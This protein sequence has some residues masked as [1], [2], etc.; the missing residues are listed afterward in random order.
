MSDDEPLQ[1]AETGGPE[2]LGEI[3][4]R[5]D[6][7]L[8]TG[9]YKDVYLAYHIE[10][11][12]DVAWNT[13]RL[14]RIPL[15]ERDRIEQETSVLGKIS[16]KN[17]IKFFHVWTNDVKKEVCFTTEIVQGGSLKSFIARVFPV[18][19]RVMKKWCFQILDALQYLH[20]K[21]PPIIH[22]D[23]KC[24][25]IFINSKDSTLMIGDFG[26][27]ALRRETSVT[28]VLGTPQFMAPELYDESYTE[29]V[30][31][32]AFGMCVLEMATNDYPYAEC[33]NP[34]QIFK[35]VYQKIKPSIIKRIKTRRVREFIEICL[36]PVHKRLS[37]RQLKNHPFFGAHPCDQCEVEVFEEEDSKP[38][39]RQEP[40]PT[41]IP[42]TEPY[43]PRK[44]SKTGHHVTFQDQVQTKNAE[45]EGAPRRRKVVSAKA[46][47]TKIEDGEA[48]ITFNIKFIENEEKK[49]QVIEFKY[50]LET[51]S[52]RA[53]CEEMASALKL[54]PSATDIL[55]KEVENALVAPP[56][57]IPQPR[58]IKKPLPVYTPKA[59]SSQHQEPMKSS[60]IAEAIVEKIVDQA[61]T[62]LDPFTPEKS[63]K[64]PFQNTDVDDE[65]PFQ[66]I[67]DQ[68]AAEIDPFHPPPLTQN[69]S[70][71]PFQP[72]PKGLTVN[73]TSSPASIQASGDGE[74]AQSNGPSSKS[75]S[76]VAG[77][78]NAERI[79]IKL[80]PTDSNVRLQGTK[81]F[82]AINRMPPPRIHNKGGL[83][84]TLTVDIKE[85]EKSQ[86][87]SP[88]SNSAPQSGSW[89][90][91][92]TTVE[93]EPPAE[94]QHSDGVGVLSTPKHS[95]VKRRIAITPLDGNDTED[96][97]IEGK[98]EAELEAIHIQEMATLER[99][100]EAMKMRLISKHEKR[101]GNLKKKNSDNNTRSRSGSA[102]LLLPGPIT[103]LDSEGIDTKSKSQ[104]RASGV[105]TPRLESGD[106]S[107]DKSST[108]PL[109]NGLRAAEDV[110]FK[111]AVSRDISLDTAH[112]SS[113]VPTPAEPK[114]KNNPPPHSE[115]KE[116]IDPTIGAILTDSNGD[117]VINGVVG[118]FRPKV[119]L[120]INSHPSSKSASPVT[121]DSRKTSPTPR[122]TLQPNSRPPPASR[123]THRS[124]PNLKPQQ[125]DNRKAYNKA[126]L[127]PSKPQ[128]DIKRRSSQRLQL[129][130][131][132]VLLNLSKDDI[133][134]ICKQNDIN[135]INKAKIKLSHK[136]RKNPQKVRQ[137]EIAAGL[138]LN[139]VET[140]TGAVR[141]E[142]PPHPQRARTP[143]PGSS[144]KHKTMKNSISANELS[145]V[146]TKLACHARSQTMSSVD[147]HQMVSDEEFLCLLDFGDGRMRSR[148]QGEVL[149]PSGQS[150][151]QKIH[152]K[153]VLE[154]KAK[155][156]AENAEKQLLQGLS[157][158]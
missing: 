83:R 110:F 158:M 57:P 41:P 54:E 150:E 29:K 154:E 146:G 43:K 108:S 10:A 115:P 3:Y 64:D 11:G 157:L 148:S 37:A 16:H 91:L 90:R 142:P 96:E 98:T 134:K 38:A 141:A 5:Y 39:P 137:I 84:T 143:S 132:C 116:Q 20:E 55:T 87:K 23:L 15:K 63:K 19:L 45:A 50:N 71:D 56:P 145:V 58:V 128:Q 121:G 131:A 149:T 100:V 118:T 81:A 82:D 12:I 1:T 17:I 36:N 124:A 53:V 123:I 68:A 73:T 151:I 135:P 152:Q 9:A 7:R 130:N 60:P 78:G 32:Y 104:S 112:P 22:R 75:N 79:P 138:L 61:S 4:K 95:Q 125:P 27:S 97:K 140:L 101:K 66:N 40:K 25:N 88:T 70:V 111:A 76:I 122:D 74:Q 80:V 92:K 46:V 52:A 69:I 59:K 94:D 107:E 18:R 127:P 114:P 136:L 109:S 21:T 13:V 6:K 35:K 102:A 106:T 65:D 119:T 126:R 67:V 117:P 44:S 34:A 89:E 49:K 144:G 155:R 156:E 2:E 42:P 62:V 85:A 28:S 30:D 86:K 77:S 51:E 133:V 31:I 8:G 105:H 120:P 147:S 93:T 33:E 72:G 113:T 103:K 129:K 24:D 47:V 14:S 99:K 26:L 153:K 48:I 139:H